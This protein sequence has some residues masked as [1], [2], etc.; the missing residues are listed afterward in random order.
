VEQEGKQ[1]VAC[2]MIAAESWVQARKQAARIVGAIY[3]TNARHCVPVTA[4]CT[5]S[6]GVLLWAAVFA[7]VAR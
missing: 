4:D 7:V 3:F 2:R 5:L 6:L 1:R